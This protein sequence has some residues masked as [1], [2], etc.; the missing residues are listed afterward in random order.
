MGVVGPLG[1]GVVGPPVPGVVGPP[2]VEP[3]PPLGTVSPGP[4]YM[5]PWP[6]LT[7]WDATT[8]LAKRADES[9]FFFMVGASAR[10][11][12]RAQTSHPGRQ[13]A[14][15][16]SHSRVLAFRSALAFRSR[17]AH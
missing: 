8:T 3:P 4:R 9:R 13:A 15:R 1:A 14:C 11:K 16:A 17:I 10:R 6:K 7:P 5:P 2:P 12:S